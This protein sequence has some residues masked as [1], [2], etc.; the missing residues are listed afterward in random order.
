MVKSL[1]LTITLSCA[2]VWGTI[3]T[4]ILIEAAKTNDVATMEACLRENKSIYVQ[5]EEGNTPLHITAQQANTVGIKALASAAPLN[6]NIKNK[7]GETPVHA[8]VRGGSTVILSYLLRNG[9]NPRATCNN[10][11]T[12]LSLALTFKNGEMLKVLWAY[13]ARPMS[14]KDHILFYR[15]G[16]RKLAYCSKL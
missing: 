8:A 5:D 1:F 14:L 12:P 7:Q 3:P 13:G 6:W 15:I 4:Q 9:G 10:G 2:H 11:F 16:S